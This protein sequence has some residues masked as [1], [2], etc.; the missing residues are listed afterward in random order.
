MKGS[1]KRRKRKRADVLLVER[2]LCESRS[3]AK[4]LIMA[5]QVWVD[6]QRVNKAGA[7]ATGGV[8]ASVGALVYSGFAI[9]GFTTVAR[10]KRAVDE[11]E[12]LHVSATENEPPL[13]EIVASVSSHSAS[14]GLSICRARK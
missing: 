3:K 7:S 2:G 14:V 5:G 6:E 11:H 10:C 12:A 8:G 1:A 13:S 4:A 9:H